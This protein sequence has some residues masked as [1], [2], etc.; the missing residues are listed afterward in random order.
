MDESTPDTNMVA[1][2]ALAAQAIS[3]TKKDQGSFL[4]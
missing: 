3:S 2:K 4:A 1:K